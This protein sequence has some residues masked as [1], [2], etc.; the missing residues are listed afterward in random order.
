MSQSEIPTFLNRCDLLYL[1]AFKEGTTKYG[2]SFN[3]MVDYMMAAKPV[4]ASYSG[5]PSMLNEADSGVFIPAEDASVI[6]EAL[7]EF[8]MMSSNE[9]DK[10]GQRG[11][12]WIL[13]HFNYTVVA[14]NYLNEI[15][16]LF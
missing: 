14:K 11:K 6:I 16:N 1:A 13:E 3:K 8:K 4:I 2:Q 9:R 5:Y 7:H 10:M 12:K 15:N